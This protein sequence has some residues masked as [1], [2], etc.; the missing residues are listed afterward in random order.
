M[1]SNILEFGDLTAKELSALDRTKTAIFLTVA[2]IEEHGPHLPLAT[3]IIESEGVARALARRLVMERPEWTFL[4]H[5]R[6]PIGTDVYTYPGSLS[7]S[8]NVLRDLV[9]DLGFSLVSSGFRIIFLAN[10]HAGP[11]HNFALEEAAR[12]V[13]Q[14]K[15]IRMV[16]LATRL[17]IDFFFRDGLQEYQ[18][19]IGEDKRTTHT[20]DHHAGSYETSEMLF[21]RPDL[22][23]SEW[24][25]LPPVL[26]P[27]GK[28]RLRSALLEAAGLGYFGTP[29][30]ASRGKGEAYVNFVVE[31]LLPDALK[32]LAGEP[33]DN[34]LPLK[35]RLRLIILKVGLDLGLI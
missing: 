24:K 10:H 8:P 13:S 14:H 30:I 22:V 11:R 26:I 3:D 16:A 27:L 1:N 33:L 25:T 2:P 17:M 32:V 28:M 18:R 9:R 15:G 20:L 19:W 23:H 21:F 34:N 6:I 5:P 7:V 12:I 35:I 31:R 29:A 4:F